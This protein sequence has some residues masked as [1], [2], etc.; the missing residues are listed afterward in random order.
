MAA[1]LTKMAGLVIIFIGLHQ[2]GLP[3][4][5]A[6][7]AEQAFSWAPLR[8][9]LVRTKAFLIGFAFQFGWAPCVG[10]IS[11]SGFSR[12]QAAEVDDA[13]KGIVVSW[14]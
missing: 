1:L 10:P 13:F 8:S 3:P 12:L 7:Y 2:A 6:L 9:R 11:G 5:R 4:I 14:R